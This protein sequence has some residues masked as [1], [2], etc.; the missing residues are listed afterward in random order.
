MQLRLDDA[1]LPATDLEFESAI[2]VTSTAR[3]R[4]SPYWLWL[5]LALPAIY[6]LGA[7]WQ[8]ALGYGEFLH[9]SGELGARLL[10]LAMVAT[11]LQMLLPR[12]SLTRWLLRNRRP[13]GV[14][15][16]GY[17]ALHALAY[18]QRKADLTRILDEAREVG[19]WTGWLALGLLLLL[20]MTS[21]D[22]AVRMLRRAWKSLHRWVYAA[23][24]L[25]Y[26]HWL[27]LAFEPLPASLHFVPLAALEA[28]RIW[29][30]HIL[31]RYQRDS[32]AE[33]V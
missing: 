2:P 13:I 9:L 28:Y 16:F 11:P 19:M 32:N 20:A 26:L 7:Y 12:L 30:R 22:A 21:N 15:A 27:L 3:A 33:H 17:S 10:I 29:S 24:L 6:W 25:T 23:A 4:S 8:D 14:A 31:P 18:L 1:I 5:V